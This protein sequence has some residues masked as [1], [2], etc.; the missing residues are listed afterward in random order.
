MKRKLK[1][2]GL[3]FL[4]IFLTVF[5]FVI[6][7]AIIDYKTEGLKSDQCLIKSGADPEQE[8]DRIDID[9]V[10]Q[11]ID[12]V[13]G[14]VTV[15][16]NFDFQ[17]CLV[18]SAERLTTDVIIATGGYQSVIKMRKGDWVNSMPVTLSLF[19][20]NVSDYPFDMHYCKLDLFAY[21]HINKTG[22]KMDFIPITLNL[23]GYVSGFLIDAR[24]ITVPADS[25]DIF[26]STVLT[27]TRS[28]TTKAVAVFIMV[29]FWV[30]SLAVFSVTLGVVFFNKKL[31]FAK[32][33]WMAAMLFAF[34]SFRTAAPGVPPIGCYFDF[35]SFFW[36]LSLLAISIVILVITWFLRKNED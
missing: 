11:S 23:R 28:K 26:T 34:F 21:T 12:P 15:L 19:N 29:M 18:D 16:L 20:G 2:Y 36:A 27:V 4:I 13:K 32:F 25:K 3:L 35:I 10:V 33:S 17:G 30:M 9:A 6:H 22:E 8:P 7:K 1:L 24:E 5:A 31:E 14:E